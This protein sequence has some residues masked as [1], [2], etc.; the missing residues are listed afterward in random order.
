MTRRTLAEWLEYQQRVHPR[1][2]DFTLERIRAVL[3]RLGGARPGAAVITVGGT[4]GKGSVT[5]LLEAVLLAAGRRVG[6]YTSPHLTRY[7]ERIR[8]D[9][10]EIDAARLVAIFERIEAARGAITLTYFEYATAAALVA[11]AEQ[12][13]D[14]VV[15]E[16][17][18]GG[19][20]DAVN[21]VDADVAVV[22]S[23]SLDHTDYL[24]ATLEDIGREKA[25]IFRA[26]R[27]ALYGSAAMPASIESEARRIGARLERLGVE[28]GAERTGAGFT[29][30]RGATTLE[31]L[32]PPAL[33][34][35]AQ[36]ANAATALAA[37]DAGGWLP[38]RAAV[39]RGLAAVRLA[40][41]YQ[42]VPG[43]VE[44][45]FDVAHNPGSAAVLA[46]T[47][48]ERRVAGRTLV[49]AGVLADKDAAA[50]AVELKR[51]LGARDLVCAVTL[52]GERGR[53]AADLAAIW[54][55][56]LGR[57]LATA[58]SVADGCAFA[59]HCAVRGDRIVVFGS[60]HTVA[61]ALEWHRL[62]S[63]ALRG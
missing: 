40:G 11:F 47:M 50:I 9:G 63:A 14:F 15:L 20:L 8:I 18:L 41:R 37:L 54:E 21:V 31:E 60:F 55:P 35:L 46:D 34:G 62:Y 45:V 56:I 52:A 58:A 16:V 59:A 57:P 42:V 61:P 2:M 48:N 36:Y 43:P 22:V 19:R 30:H 17:G 51:A 7:E 25:G 39:A 6:L 23:I 29:F 26:G 49:V 24:G 27:P 28:F 4:N 13:L 53:T 5:A 10:R 44:W 33:A 1:A 32:P 3:A 38:A 12:P